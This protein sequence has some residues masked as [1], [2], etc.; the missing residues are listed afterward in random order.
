MATTFNTRIQ[1]KYDTYTNWSTNNPVLLKGELALVEVPAESGTG[2]QEP[3]YLLKIGDGTKQFSALDWVSGKAADVYAWAKAAQKP[4][5]QA[6]EITGLDA[7]IQ[8]KVQD[9]NTK[10]QI[11]KNGDMGFKLQS[12]ELNSE[13]WVD[14]NEITL[15]APTYTLVEGTENGTVKFN[16]TDVKVHGLG[17]AAYT[18]ASAYETAGARTEL[19]GTA[20]DPSTANTINAAK[21]HADEKIAALT[22]AGETAAIGEVISAVSQANGVITV[23]KKTLTA[24]D[25]PTVEMSKVNGLTGAL[26]GKQDTITFNSP[27][28]SDTNKAATM[29]DVQS[30]VAGL[31]GAMHYVG[32]STT[33]PSINVTIEAKPEY[34][35]VAGDVVTYQKKEFVYDGETWRELGDE[36]SFAI[37]GSIKDADIASDANIAKSKINGLESDLATINSN[38]DAVE[39]LVGETPVATQITNAINALDKTDAVVENQFVT[40]VTQE[41]GIITVQRNRPTIANIDGLTEAL[42]A[43]ANDAGLAT[44]AKT[45]KIDDLTQTDV[46]IFNCGTSAV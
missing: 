13:D 10:Y 12:K 29:A 34:S 36:S 28:D 27:Y 16:G 15:V 22:N 46:I 18:E 6:N 14:V 40:S 42:A 1:L 32:E 25:I 30:A 9:T 23:Q 21:K 17:S 4:E 20:S 35:P 31:T 8:G 3:S 5:Y 11:V 24:E 45:G 38:I 37:K 43:K 26:A 7:Y 19:I 44:V 41:N 39:A 33:D 2:L